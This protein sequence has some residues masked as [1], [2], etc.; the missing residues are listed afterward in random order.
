MSLTDLASEGKLKTHKTSKAEIDQ[1][2]AVFDRDIADAKITGL[3]TD[4]RFVMT[5]GSALSISI[6]ALAACGYRA[7]SEGHHY[8]TIQSLAFTLGTDPKTVDKLNKFRQKRNIA[9]YERIGMASEKEVREM[10]DLANKLRL[11]FVEWLKKN[12]PELI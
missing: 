5:Y 7:A 2:L 3:S 1:L 11:D 9:D 10:L 6:A 4:R 12:H 8:W